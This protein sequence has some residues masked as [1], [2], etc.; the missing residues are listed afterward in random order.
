MCVFHKREGV[1]GLGF[2]TL[3]VSVHRALPPIKENALSS[4]AKGTS[5]C[6]D[7]C[8]L[9]CDSNDLQVST[10]ARSHCR[11]RRFSIMICPNRSSMFTWKGKKVRHYHKGFSIFNQSRLITANTG[12]R[13]VALVHS[14]TTV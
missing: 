13:G 8:S 12:E 6:L 5:E 10:P 14:V 9:T 4:L 11:L 7:L 1:A 3:A 2:E